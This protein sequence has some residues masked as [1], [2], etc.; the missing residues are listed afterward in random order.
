M[1]GYI[2][3]QGLSY[4]L[5]I[6]PIIFIVCHLR[7]PVTPGSMY[8][9]LCTWLATMLAVSA[10]HFTCRIFG[11]KCQSWDEIFN[12]SSDFIVHWYG[13]QH[14]CYVSLFEERW[15]SHNHEGSYGS[16]SVPALSVCR[17]DVSGRGAGSSNPS[18]TT[19]NAASQPYHRNVYQQSW[20]KHDWIYPLVHCMFS[21]SGHVLRSFPSNYGSSYDRYLPAPFSKSS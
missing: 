3:Y 8:T 17:F 11:A 2:V 7:A 1:F 20:Q 14:T 4:G 13:T 9:A 16:A 5:D 15:S 21:S 12:S 10:A 6:A 18:N 19:R